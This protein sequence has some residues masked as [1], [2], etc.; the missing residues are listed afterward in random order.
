MGTDNPEI[1]PRPEQS[2]PTVRAL[3]GFDADP[4]LIQRDL[5]SIQREGDKISIQSED[6]VTLVVGSPTISADRTW[7]DTTKGRVLMR[8][9]HENDTVI[10]DIHNGNMEVYAD[11]G[12]PE[13]E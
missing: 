10:V 8:V 5:T 6:V 12:I 1:G 3:F 4:E 11:P 7:F 13:G 9:R 2:E